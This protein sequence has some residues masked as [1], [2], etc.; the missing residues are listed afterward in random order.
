MEQQNSEEGKLLLRAFQ[1]MCTAKSMTELYEAQREITSKYVHATSRGHEAV[2]IALGLLME[3]KDYLSL[4][5]A[6]VV[7]EKGRPLFRW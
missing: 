1:L 5:D 3:A 2:Q 6:S 7:G 4:F